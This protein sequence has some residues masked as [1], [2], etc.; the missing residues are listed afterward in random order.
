MMQWC[1]GWLAGWQAGLREATKQTVTQAYR[2]TDLVLL[3]ALGVCLE[4]MHAY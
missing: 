3:H 1:D 2:S 4:S